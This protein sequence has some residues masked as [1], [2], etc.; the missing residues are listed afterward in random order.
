MSEDQT[1]PALLV[2]RPQPLFDM[3]CTNPYGPD[4]SRA[5]SADYRGRWLALLFY[6]R[7]FTFVCPTELIAHSACIADFHA[8]DCQVLGVSVDPV[9]RHEEWLMTPPEAGGVGRLRFPLATDTHGR[10]AREMGVYLAEKGV[11]CRALFLIDPDGIVQY[12]VVHNLD[13]GRST[14]ET[15]RVLGALQGG[16]LCPANWTR[17]DGTLDPGALLQP[18]RVLGHYRIRRPIGEGAFGQ[19]LEAWDETLERPVALKVL[20]EGARVD[21][22]AALHEARSAGALNH[23]AICT[24]YAVER[25]EG[26]PLIAMEL[27]SGESLDRRLARGIPDETEARRIA[28]D[29][30]DAL[31]ASHAAGV[32]HGD[33]KPAN[34]ML[35]AEGQSKLLDFGIAQRRGRTV[36]PPAPPRPRTGATA[37]PTLLTIDETVA[38][39]RSVPRPDSHPPSSRGSLRGTPAYMAPEQLSGSASTEASDAYG[40]GLILYELA[41]GKQAYQADSLESLIELIESLDP[42]LLVETAPAWAQSALAA[43]LTHD[44]D[45]RESM[46]EVLERLSDPCVDPLPT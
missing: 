14:D 29:V 12:Q 4:R 8:L 38:K 11:A 31:A 28:R 40:F 39:A 32:I 2:G 21:V 42:R 45:E 22:E 37:Q 13:V 25:P 27:L 30:A 35:T 19:V 23:P 7:D 41:T 36:A 43:V 33:L 3:P 10:L 26:V 1:R 17:A 44:P 24:I 18:G 5:R 46:S 15:L 6:P 20:R 9:E 34:V 16:G